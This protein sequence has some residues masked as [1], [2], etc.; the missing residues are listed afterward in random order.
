VDSYV[1]PDYITTLYR[2]GDDESIFSV[3]IQQNHV[4]LELGQQGLNR[5]RLH[6]ETDT[7]AY[8]NSSYPH[9]IGLVYQPTINQTSSIDLYIDGNK[10]ETVVSDVS[11]FEVRVLS[12]YSPT[13]DKLYRYIIE[14]YRFFHTLGESPYW[15]ISS[16][17]CEYKLYFPYEFQSTSEVDVSRIGYIILIVIICALLCS[18]MVYGM[19]ELIT[20]YKA[21]H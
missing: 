9:H 16:Y 1:E 6:F 21:K 10:M 2:F 4:I 8:I 7:R 13:S 14:Q 15:M 5:H 19:V 20:K 18:S 11:A 12:Y 3:M 17:I